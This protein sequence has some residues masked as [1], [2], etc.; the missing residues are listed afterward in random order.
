MFGFSD[1]QSIL[2]KG[3]GQHSL[4]VIFHIVPRDI[5]QKPGPVFQGSNS[6]K[7]DVGLKN[8]VQ[9]KPT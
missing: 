4:I 3:S 7:A 2:T 5:V 6:V 8:I 1:V 9:T